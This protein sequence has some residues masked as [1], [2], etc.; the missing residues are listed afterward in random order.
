MKKIFAASVGILFLFVGFVV[1]KISKV[2]TIP[3]H[4]HAN[5]AVFIDGVQKDFTKP[6]LM[7]IKPCTNDES[8]SSE[9]EE[10]V[11]LHDQVGN[12]V[13]LH[14]AGISWRTFFHSIKFDLNSFTNEKELSVYSKGE[15]VSP[16]YLDQEIQKQDQVLI[17]IASESA[18]AKIVDDSNLIK[19][20]EAVGTSAAEYDAGKGGAEKCGAVGSRT[21]W[22]RFKLAF[23]L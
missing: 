12:V 13:H 16:G 8:E 22:Q 21:L 11:H 6:S 2:P 10:N 18:A 7:H 3:V 23:G 14:A 20:S 1:F 4:Y 17:H 9:P 19:E 5:F 15:K